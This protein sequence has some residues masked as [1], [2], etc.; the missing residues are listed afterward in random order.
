MRAIVRAATP[1]RPRVSVVGLVVRR[2]AVLGGSM[3][4]RRRVVF[5]IRSW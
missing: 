4:T 2:R 1:G 5:R 3:A